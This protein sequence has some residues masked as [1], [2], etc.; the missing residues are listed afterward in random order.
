VADITVV[1]P[2]YRRPG[3]LTRL[4]AGLAAQADPPP[5]QLVV[6]DNDPEP[7]PEPALPAGAR[8]VREPVAGA[9]AARNRG[10]A[11]TTTPLLAML[12]DDVV[13]DPGWLRQL[14][15]PVLAGRA[16]V[17]G[18]RVLLDPAA[19]RPTWLS[20]AIEGYLTAL[21]LGPYEA[22][23]TG[24]Q[25]LLT[26]NLLTRTQLLRDIGG[27]DAAL[28]PRPGAQL[29]ADDDQLVRR[30]REAGARAH[31]VPHAVVVHEL[32]AER[33][34]RRWLLRRAYLQGRSDWRLDRAELECR[35][36]HGGRVALA[37]WTEQ[38]QQRRTEG[39]RDPAVAFH[40]ACDLARTLGAVA[41][42]SSWRSPRTARDGL[43]P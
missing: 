26:A 31:W 14:A 3:S 25:S 13:P 40:A 32:P 30:L 22:E 34:R 39:L 27:F 24:S 8:L 29:V 16:D 23:L 7:H 20:P 15:E 17:A 35:K 4:L 28:G 21:D 10:I 6:V 41:E 12:D 5:Y 33:L 2:T 43:S 38:L 19:T 37:W 36:A 18:G 11:E 1:V 9:A 42:A